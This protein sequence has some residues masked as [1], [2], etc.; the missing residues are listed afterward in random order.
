[1]EAAVQ[2]KLKRNSPEGLKVLVQGAGGVGMALIKILIE[3]KA[4]VLV[5]E[6]KENIL[7]TVKTQF[8]EIKEVDPSE[9]I[10]TPCDIF[11]PCALGSVI[12]ESNLHK[13]KCSIIAG[14]ANNQLSTSALAFELFKQGICYVPDFVANSGGLIQVFSNWK[15]YPEEW[16]YKKIEGIKE[17]IRNI[18]QLSEQKSI[19]TSEVAIAIA[20]EHIDSKK[21]HFFTGH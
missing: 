16:L 10:E 21:S 15:K 1:M 9:I 6:V 2:W 14:G 4:E 17:K 13:L 5:S 20:Q 12:T 19:A 7:S 11:S 3:R 8:P 18:C